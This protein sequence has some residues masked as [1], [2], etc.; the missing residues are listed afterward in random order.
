MEGRLE[1][2]CVIHWT[3]CRCGHERLRQTICYRAGHENGGMDVE[4]RRKKRSAAVSLSA[5]MAGESVGI[6]VWGNGM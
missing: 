4:D 3:P 6:G 2:I 1:K 5:P